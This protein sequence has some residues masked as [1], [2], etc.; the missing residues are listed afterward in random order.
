[1]LVTAELTTD[2]R[3]L[4]AAEIP[5]SNIS[6]LYEK[7]ILCVTKRVDHVIDI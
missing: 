2:R 4:P 7:W 6:I 5:I 1:M 3:K